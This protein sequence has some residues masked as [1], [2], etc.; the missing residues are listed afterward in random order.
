MT[1]SKEP[2]S[3]P[4][5]S[6][7]QYQSNSTSSP[8]GGEARTDTIIPPWEAGYE[9]VDR[10]TLLKTGVSF[11][12]QALDVPLEDRNFKD[13]PQ[14]YANFIKELFWSP[15]PSITTFP[16]Q[17]DQMVIL[18]GHECWTLCPHHL[19][20]VR[21]NF[22]AAYIPRGSV[23]G[24]S[25]LARLFDEVNTMPLMQ[26]TVTDLLCEKLYELTGSMGAGV[27]MRGE[28]LC[29]KMRGI[30]SPADMVT[31]KVLGVISS[32]PQARNEFLQFVAHPLM[33]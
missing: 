32:N 14:R 8:S 3:L 25:K 20:P 19:L 29:M 13:T 11:I 5:S 7:S 2:D 16:E 18:R 27:V 12:L 31:S 9:N 30:K 4:Q 23:L 33:R 10:E 24:V 6:T 17:H 15:K 28:H 21:F 1:T 22:A 26:E